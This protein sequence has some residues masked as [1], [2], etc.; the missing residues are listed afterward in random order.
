MLRIRDS[1]ETEVGVLGSVRERVADIRRAKEQ[2]STLM[3]QL[4]KEKFEISDLRDSSRRE[5]VNNLLSGSRS[6]YDRAC[7]SSSMSIFDWLLI[8]DMLNSS[9][10]HVRKAEEV[11]QAEPYV[12]LPTSFDTSTSSTSF[13]GDSGGFGG[14]GGFSGG[15]GSDGTY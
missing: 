6:M 10:D 4:S 7:Q 11:S 13:G 12:P 5:E 9:Q 2:S 3:Q 15:S 8:N 1:A 14:G